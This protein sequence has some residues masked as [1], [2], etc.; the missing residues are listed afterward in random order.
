MAIPLL[1]DALK[2][3]PDYPAA[4]AFLSRCFHHRY[5]RLGLREEDRI[6]AVQHARAAIAHGSDDATALAVAAYIVAY[7]DRD[8]ATALK[9]FDRALELS[10]SNVFALGFSAVIH[11]WMGKTE[12]AIERAQ[13]AIRLSPFD[14][15]NFRAYHALAIA[16]F[17]SQR[18]VDAMDAARSAV[19]ADPTFAPGHAVM[20]AALWRLGRRAE[21]KA[22]ARD[23]LEHDPTFTIRRL[24]LIVELEP[25]V[26][27]PLADAW[28]ELGLPE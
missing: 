8:T 23:V 9:L 16:H 5:A 28:R 4:H 25:A 26:F 3:Q 17:C 27:M 7:D 6:A 14:I 19:H 10:G 1:E 15:Y 20:A 24:S 13:L 11:A 12:V 2:L 21:A 18:Y 22:A